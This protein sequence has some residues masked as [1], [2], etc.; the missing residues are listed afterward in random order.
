MVKS[1]NCEAS[2]YAVFS[3]LL[4]LTPHFDKKILPVVSYTWWGGCEPA[5]PLPKNGLPDSMN[6]CC[7]I[8]IVKYNL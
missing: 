7:I 5:N 6:L 3:R 4:Y 8:R 1:A 2:H